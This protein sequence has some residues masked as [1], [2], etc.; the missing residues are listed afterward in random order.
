MSACKYIMCTMRQC[1]II[2]IVWTDKAPWMVSAISKPI[3]CNSYCLFEECQIYEL[4][5]GTIK[6]WHGILALIFVPPSLP[7][8]SPLLPHTQQTIN[9]SI[10]GSISIRDFGDHGLPLIAILCLSYRSSIVDSHPVSD[11]AEPSVPWSS[12]S[13][14]AIN[15]TL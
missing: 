15:C 5:R 9:Q 1:Y 2:M 10:M 12:L 13:P 8:P 4:Q 14:L 11:V 6:V 3:Q 7:S